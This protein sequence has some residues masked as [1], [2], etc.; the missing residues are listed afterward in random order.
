[1]SHRKYIDFKLIEKVPNKYNIK[2]KDI[3]KLYE[4]SGKRNEIFEYDA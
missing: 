4:C 1:M 3:K 2:P